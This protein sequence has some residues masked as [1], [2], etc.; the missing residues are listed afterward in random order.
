MKFPCEFIQGIHADPFKMIKNLSIKEY[1]ALKEHV[2]T[3]YNCSRLL[4][5]ILI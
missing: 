4:D 2:Q 5:E 3:C 1:Y